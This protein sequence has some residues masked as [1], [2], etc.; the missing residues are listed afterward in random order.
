V[1]RTLRRRVRARRASRATG[2]SRNT[3]LPRDRCP[4]RSAR[5]YDTT[6][7]RPRAPAPGGDRR[8]TATCA[9]TVDSGR[10]Q[11][12]PS[13]RHARAPSR[14]G[15]VAAGPPVPA[16]PH[17]PVPAAA[18]SAGTTAGS[19][20]RR[21]GRGLEPYAAAARA[22]ARGADSAAMRR[23][24]VNRPSSYSYTPAREAHPRD[25]TPG[26]W[27]WTASWC[28]RSSP[29]RAPS[30]SPRCGNAARPFLV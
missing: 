8:W 10:S 13:G 6:T 20:K 12:T 5:A 15:A 28:T 14:T 1:G 19:I 29:F 9:S 16:R 27:T 11:P 30:S 25:P 23:R 22:A 26:S 7:V 21:A 24:V 17:P 4:T 3:P 18:C 2:T